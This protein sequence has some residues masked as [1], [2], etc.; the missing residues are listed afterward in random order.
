MKSNATSEEIAEHKR[1][2]AF[3]DMSGDD[4]IYKYMTTEGKMYGEEA[5]KY[6]MLEYLQKS[7]GVFNQNGMLSKA[8]VKET[9]RRAQT[10]EKNLWHGFISFNKENS[11]KIDDPEKCIALVKKMFGQ[12]F[13]DAGFNPDNMDLMCALHLDRPEHL[14]I[15]YV[16][17][18]KEPKVKNQRAAGY[19][20]RKKGKIPLEV[21]DKMTER[22]NDYTLDDDLAEKRQ[23][24]MRALRDVVIKKG[25]YGYAVTRD[26]LR[27]K[28]RS[29]AD[30]LP[31]D[32]PLW[33]ASKE[34]APYRG[35]IDD[36]VES[37]TVLSPKFFYADRAFRQELKDK[38]QKLG[39]I[40][41]NYYKERREKELHNVQNMEGFTEIG[42]GL[43][44]LHTIE[45]LEWDYR[46]R[47]GNI[48]LY[49]IR[50]IQSATYK[51]NPRQKYKT[52]DKNL[53]R[54]LAISRRKVNGIMDS[55]FAS[56][57]EL[58]SPETENYHNR[59]REIEQ[60]MQEENE[61]ANKPQPSSSR[62]WDWGK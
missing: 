40:M 41:G 26:E 62:R 11:D 34:M 61:K 56:V 37:L 43:K 9:K 59:L 33:Y 2:R 21:I 35:E 45:A 54:R 60:E 4:N 24:A 14:H 50:D 27:E 7:T 10:G 25:G 49:R 29:L 38:Q 22:L 16:F 36:I 44:N 39:A 57:A 19:I 8:E 18:E 20:Y 12:F 5:K 17:W 55:L 3:Y 28:L 51:R 46:R 42:D 48:V 15:H 23:K 47:L 31:K 6:T 1:L 52:N 30:K 13:K 58:F 53:K 32:K